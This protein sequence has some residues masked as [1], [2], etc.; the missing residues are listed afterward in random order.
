MRILVYTHA[1]ETTH[2]HAHTHSD[3]SGSEFEES[4]FQSSVYTHTH[5]HTLTHKLSHM[6]AP[7]HIRVCVLGACAFEAFPPSLR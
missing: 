4:E 1:C 2:T 7:V 5:T 3:W 6:C